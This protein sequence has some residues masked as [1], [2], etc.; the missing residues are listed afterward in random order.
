MEFALHLALRINAATR[1][2][3]TKVRL[4]MIPMPVALALAD[5]LTEVVNAETRRRSLPISQSRAK[6]S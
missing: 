2:K 4:D 1:L 3:L 5:I 6:H